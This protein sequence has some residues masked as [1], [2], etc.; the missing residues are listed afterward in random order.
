MVGNV[1][2]LSDYKWQIV[3]AL[4]I[5]AGFFLSRG[6]LAALAPAARVAVPILAVWLVFR[7]L[8]KKLT[9]LAGGAMK[10]RLEEMMKQMAQQQ[11]QQGG[12]SSGGVI[13]LCPGCGAY[14]KPGHKC[15]GSKA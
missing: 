13:D 10:G 9:A 3:A 2:K 1:S 5:V 6:G 12:R 4:A 11:G 14:L 8:R 15:K 7:L